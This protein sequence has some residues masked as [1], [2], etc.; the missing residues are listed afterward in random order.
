MPAFATFCIRFG[1]LSL[2]GSAAVRSRQGRRISTHR[3]D[4]TIF[5]RSYPPLRTITGGVQVIR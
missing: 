5:E 1:L 4:F 3:S 2:E